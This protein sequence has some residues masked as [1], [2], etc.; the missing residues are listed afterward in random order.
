MNDYQ[1]K[2]RSGNETSFSFSLERLERDSIAGA[3]ADASTAFD[4]FITDNSNAV[5]HSD[6]IDG[7]SSDARFAAAANRGINFCSHFDSP[8]KNLKKLS[9]IL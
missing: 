2:R 1:K 7:A 8:V 5:F 6:C 3:F 4:A 9:V